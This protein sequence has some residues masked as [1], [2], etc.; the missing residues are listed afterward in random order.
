MQQL[1]RSR[2]DV[3]MN[4]WGWV[5]VVVGVVIATV[6]GVVSMTMISTAAWLQRRRGHRAPE[7]F[8]WRKEDASEESAGTAATPKAVPSICPCCGQE[9]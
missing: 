7:P 6:V 9:T 4:P 8:D 1:L 3:G 2:G 5:L